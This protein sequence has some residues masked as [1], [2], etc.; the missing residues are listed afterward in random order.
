MRT[1]IALTMA[2]LLGS[3]SAWAQTDNKK[4]TDKPRAGSGVGK[5]DG[6]GGQS[7]S[8]ANPPTNKKTDRSSTDTGGE[9]NEQLLGDENSKAKKAVD[10]DASN[11]S[12]KASGNPNNRSSGSEMNQGTGTSQ[13]SSSSSSGSSTT[14]SDGTRQNSPGGTGNASPASADTTTQGV[15][16]T[17]P[18]TGQEGGGSAGGSSGS[19]PETESG[20]TTGTET[21]EGE[22]EEASNVS[23]IPSSD[24]SPAGSPASLSGNNGAEPDGTNNKQRASY[25]MA[26]SPVQNMKLDK[27]DVSTNEEI[28][29]T[30]REDRQNT[31]PVNS[32]MLEQ[33]KKDPKNTTDPAGSLNKDLTDDGNGGREASLNTQEDPSAAQSATQENTKEKPTKKESRKSKRKSRKSDKDNS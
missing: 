25:N 24:S 4:K 23:A 31:P 26:G 19:S 21:R 11:R 33:Q 15:P 2:L 18:M 1:L 29:R 22:N 7:G 16:N 8:T 5:Q 3:A 27:Q 12:G 10:G 20:S 13:P 17:G 30:Q 32:H 6:P 9:D 28:K 14:T